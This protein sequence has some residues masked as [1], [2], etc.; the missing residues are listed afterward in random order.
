[1]EKTARATILLSAAV[2]LAGGCAAWRLWGEIPVSTGPEAG[3]VPQAPEERRKAAL[4]H[5]DLG[6]DTVDVSSYPAA[7][8]R[9]Y[10]VYARAC[11]RCHTLARSINAPYANRAW[12]EFYIARM[13]ARAGFHGERLDRKEIKAVLDFLQHDDRERKLGRPAE[14]EAE[15]RELRRRFEAALDERMERLQKQPLPRL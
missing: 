6:P 2:L 11:S 4:F 10:E 1:M 8:R 14:F 5:S 12:W 3:A 13:R 7:R 9:D 15:Q